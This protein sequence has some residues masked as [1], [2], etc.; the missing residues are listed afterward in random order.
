MCVSL[1]K[2][3]VGSQPSTNSLCTS[4][5]GHSFKTQFS[6]RILIFHTKYLTLTKEILPPRK[7]QKLMFYILLKII[8]V[9]D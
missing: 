9:K 8:N 6:V 3:L 7:H 4:G 1:A 5:I 2:K